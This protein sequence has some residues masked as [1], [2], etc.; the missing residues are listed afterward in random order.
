MPFI[1]TAEN[2]SNPVSAT[3]ATEEGALAKATEFIT[4]G[5]SEV[6]VTDPDGRIWTDIEYARRIQQL[7]DAAED[8]PS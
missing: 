1:I 2:Q 6:R 4:Q 8:A 5:M 7:A 3:R